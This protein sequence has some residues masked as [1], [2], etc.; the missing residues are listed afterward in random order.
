MAGTMRRTIRHRMSRRTNGRANRPQPTTPIGVSS[1]SA[2]G[3]VLTVVFDQPVAL[4]GVPAYTTDVAGAVA[5]SAAMSSAT[6]LDLTF[7]ADVSLATVVNI[8]YEDPAVRNA[9][10]GFVTPTSFQV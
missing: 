2:A 1:V 6:T 8:P 9:S 3:A 7:D 5:I 4:D 10:G